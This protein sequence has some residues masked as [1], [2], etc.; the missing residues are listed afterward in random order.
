MNTIIDLIKQ[1]VSCPKLA[2]NAPSEQEL[3][4][5]LACALRAPDHGRLKPWHF[6]IVQGDARNKLGYVFEKAAKESG[7]KLADKLMKCRNMPLRAPMIVVAVCEPI[8][9]VKISPE[10]QVLAVGAAIQNMQIAI[11]SLEYGSIWRTGDMSES[12][13]VKDAFGLSDAGSIVGFVYVGEPEKKP[14]VQKPDIQ[15]R[16][17]HWEG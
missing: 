15:N 11:S 10:E 3:H 9:N 8:L 5:I 17:S 14:A 4:E 7:V 12:K 6:H 13:I 1:R 2:G 16:F